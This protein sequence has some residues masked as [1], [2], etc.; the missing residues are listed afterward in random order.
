MKVSKERYINLCKHKLEMNKF[1][2]SLGI[3]NSILCLFLY[4]VVLIIICSGYQR[5]DIPPYA[6]VIGL[7][8]FSVF[9]GCC[10]IIIIRLAKLI[11]ERKELKYK[12]FLTENDG[13]ISSTLE[14]EYSEDNNGDSLE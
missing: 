14:N 6:V 13:I 5:N 7:I 11:I 2:I 1:D 8:L 4:V 9:C 3:I 10:T 12:L